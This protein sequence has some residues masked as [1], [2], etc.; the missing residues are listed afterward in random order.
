MRPFRLVGADTSGRIGT[1]I[2][3]PDR[4]RSS[5]RRPTS[6]AGRR[7][8]RVPSRKRGSNDSREP[9][10]HGLLWVGAHE[11]YS[12]FEPAPTSRG[13]RRIWVSRRCSKDPGQR[14]AP[15]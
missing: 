4:A 5:A 6:L 10:N 1:L 8:K 11:K 7:G 12:V 15:G 2:V 14:G 9:R 13:E 3:T